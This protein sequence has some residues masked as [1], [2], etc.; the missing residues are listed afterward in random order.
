[1]R[2]IPCIAFVL[3]ALALAGCGSS[4]AYDDRADKAAIHD[5]ISSAWKAEYAGDESTACLYYT[6]AFI[7]Q[8]NR[9][10]EGG[11]PGALPHRKD[12]ATGP[13]GYH[14]YLRFTNVQGGFGNDKVGFEWT[15]VSGKTRTATVK[16]ILP[17]GVR[18]LNPVDCSVVISLVIH[19]VGE[20]GRGWLIDGLDASI[21]AVHGSCSPL[22]SRQ[23]L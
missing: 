3:L 21:C 14:P 17:G 10:W 15:R 16:P 7:E 6:K 19:L 11:A 22:E 9:V 1:M 12:C 4:A 13:I 18:C 23:V 8:Q 5:V 2:V 20:K